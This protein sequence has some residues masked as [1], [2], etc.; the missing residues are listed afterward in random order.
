LPKKKQPLKPQPR[1]QPKRQP[2]KRLQQKQQRNKSANTKDCA[3][4]TEHIVDK[5][6]RGLR[7]NKGTCMKKTYIRPFSCVQTVVLEPALLV[8]SGVVGS[9][10]IFDDKNVMKRYYCPY[11]QRLYC[12][13][14]SKHMNDWAAVV[15]DYAKQGK[16]YLFHTREVC[17]YE[18]ECDVYKLYT[19]YK[20][21]QKQM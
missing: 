17:S 14:Y 15:A 3:E 5:M 4:P 11:A 19:F 2:K 13:R 12:E 16:D 6:F 20:K 1:Q 7:I 9:S 21:H 18:N 8:G 10:S